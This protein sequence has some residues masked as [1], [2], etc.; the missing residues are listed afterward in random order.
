M[1]TTIPAP[2]HDAYREAIRPHG[3]LEEF[4]CQ[5]LATARWYYERATALAAKYDSESPEGIRFQNMA[6]R[7]E[8]SYN[9]A[10]RELRQ[11]QTERAL[12]NPN[13]HP[14]LADLQ[15][16]QQVAKR[17]GRPAPSTPETPENPQPQS[18]QHCAKRNPDPYPEAGRNSPCPCGSGKKYKRCCGVD[19]PPILHAA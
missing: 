9:R 18:D 14:P 8:G 15:K 5:R 17:N 7:W 6:L 12:A 19:A 16:I 10:M 2:H 3:V 1:I 4:A 11:L 13:C